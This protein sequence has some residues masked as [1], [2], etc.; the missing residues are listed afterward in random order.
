MPYTAVIK[1]PVGKIGIIT[2]NDHLTAVHFLPQ[3]AKEIAPKDTFSKN[4]IQQLERYFKN[5]KTVFNIPIQLNGTPFQNKVWQQLCKISAGKTATYGNLAKILDTGAR[6]IGAGCRTNPIP[7][8]IPCHR[9]VAQNGLG[10]FCGKDKAFFL[11][12]KKWLLAHES[13]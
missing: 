7:I 9:V 6:A 8:V 11:E 1:T 4:V 10:G 2:D 12:I 5:P 13:I 3:A